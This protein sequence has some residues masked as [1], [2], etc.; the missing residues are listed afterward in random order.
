MNISVVPGTYV[1]PAQKYNTEAVEAPPPV[2]NRPYKLEK[3][4]EEE[5]QDQTKPQSTYGPG[6]KRDLGRYVDV[7]A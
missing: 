6:T 3:P 4:T 7:A 2:E 5:K 1:Y